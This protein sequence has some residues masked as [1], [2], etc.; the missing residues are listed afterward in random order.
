MICR[1][2][3]WA[4]GLC[5]LLSYPGFAFFSAAYENQI[6]AWKKISRKTEY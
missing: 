4:K 5:F 1:Q 3:F 6:K 2:I